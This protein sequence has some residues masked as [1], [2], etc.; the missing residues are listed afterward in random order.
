VLEG[1][2]VEQQDDGGDEVDHELAQDPV[3]ANQ[4]QA[5][6]REQTNPVASEARLKGTRTTQPVSS[7]TR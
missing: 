7:I 5:L 1:L 6:P 2:H 3:V 4:A